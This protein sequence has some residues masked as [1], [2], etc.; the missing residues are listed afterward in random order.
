MVAG[1]GPRDRNAAVLERA[2]IFESH[3]FEDLLEYGQ[4]LDRCLLNETILQI[5]DDAH[6]GQRFVLNKFLREVGA[7]VLSVMDQKVRNHN[8]LI[9][10]EGSLAVL[11]DLAEERADLHVGLTGVLEQLKLQGGLTLVRKE[12]M[13][14][15]SFQVLQAFFEAHST[16]VQSAKLLIA[17]RHIVHNEQENELVVRVALRLNLLKH[18]VRFLKQDQALLK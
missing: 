9:R 17:Q 13:N 12:L 8:R 7:H 6:L 11:V 5:A 4:Q 18:R 3:A 16:F 10:V 2:L 15:I 14:F 1:K